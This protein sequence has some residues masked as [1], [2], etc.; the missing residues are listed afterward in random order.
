[1]DGLTLGPL[2]FS[3]SRGAV[4]IG[5]IV[6]ILVAWLFGRRVGREINTWASASAFVAV[7]AARLGHVVAHS[8]IYLADPLTAFAFWQGGFDPIW[9]AVGFALMSALY[10]WKRPRLI[11]PAV[12]SLALGLVGWNGAY[13][14]LRGPDLTLPESVMLT[15]L[16]GES[17]STSDWKGRPMV[18]N[19]WATWCPPCRRELPMMADVAASVEGVD[20]HFINQGESPDLVRQYL[21]REGIDIA[22]ILDP[23]SSMMRHART[24]G[25][26]TTLFIDAEGR[27]RAS[28]LGEISRA[29][30][31]DG[32]GEIGGSGS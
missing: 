6:L 13:Q 21:L 16:Q 24:Q 9:G 26:P 5:L 7:I 14:L 2:A 25:L 19:L 18:I 1:M 12:V 29:Q 23:G 28:H 20:I 4:L 3:A 32:I 11:I 31:L 27:I 8:D 30:L 17:V 15:S 10:L 22:P